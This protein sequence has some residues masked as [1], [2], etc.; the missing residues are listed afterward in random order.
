MT[1]VGNRLLA[2]WLVAL[3]HRLIASE[4]RD[5]ADQEENDEDYDTVE[6][7]DEDDEATDEDGRESPPP[8]SHQ[9]ADIDLD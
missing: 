8:D 9:P 6:E 7:E 4:G 3:S 2:G 5:A 1:N